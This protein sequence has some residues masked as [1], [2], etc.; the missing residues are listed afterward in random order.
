MHAIRCALWKIYAIAI[1]NE[2]YIIQNDKPSTGPLP[3]HCNGAGQ[4]LNE[5]S[6]KHWNNNLM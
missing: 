2:S 4:G 6:T 3:K 1:R 5:Q